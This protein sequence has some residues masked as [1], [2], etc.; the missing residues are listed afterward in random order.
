MTKWETYCDICGKE[1]DND[2]DV[3]KRKFYY[4]IRSVELSRAFRQEPC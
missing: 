3:S 2:N 1:I 4:E